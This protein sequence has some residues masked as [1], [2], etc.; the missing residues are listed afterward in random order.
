MTEA[1]YRKNCNRLF[2]GVAP[3]LALTTDPRRWARAFRH[4]GQPV[5]VRGDAARVALK[6]A[7]AV[8]RIEAQKA[9]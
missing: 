9:A 4:S 3:E 6:T 1:T 5:K 2:H 8:R 7:R